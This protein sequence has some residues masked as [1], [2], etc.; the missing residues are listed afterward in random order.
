MKSRSTSKFDC[1]CNECGRDIKAGRRFYFFDGHAHCS[2]KCLAQGTAREQAE[3]EPEVDRI[4]DE[5]G[6][7]LAEG[8]KEPAS[9]ALV[10]SMRHL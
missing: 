3:S 10:H 1:V 7:R 8:E 5:C 4:C 6:L 9:H 2:L